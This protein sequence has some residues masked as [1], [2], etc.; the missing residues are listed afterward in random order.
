MLWQRQLGI[1]QRHLAPYFWD[2]LQLLIFFVQIGTFKETGRLLGETTD[3]QEQ[4]SMGVRKTESRIPANFQAGDL[5]EAVASADGRCTLVSF[6]NSPLVVNRENVYILFVT[7]PGLAAAAQTFKWTFTE[8]GGTPDVQTIQIGELPYLPKVT[9]TLSVSVRILGAGNAEQANVEMSQDVVKPNAELEDLIINSTN[10][11]GAGLG[12]PDVAREL[13]NDHNPYYQGVQL[14]TPESGDGFKRFVFSMVYDGALERSPAH[15]KEH[16]DQLAASLNGG[17]GD[18][19]ALTA[20]GIGASGI[21]LALLTMTLDNSPALPWTELP[22][23]TSQRALADEELREK[24]TALDENTRIDLFN[25]ARFP[26][27]NITQCGRILESLRNRYF[28]RAN[29]NDV[30]TGMS[31]TRAFWIR[32]HFKEGPIQHS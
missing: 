26:K 30:L 5:G 16:L 10:V 31:G 22:E 11:P 21:R 25:L 2:K 3:L 7:D 12:N 19:T 29:F 13:V 15:R 32:R 4:L 23:A 27:S 9:G 24:L 28:S 1:R 8:N 18:F 20:G 17:A 6:I 14:Q